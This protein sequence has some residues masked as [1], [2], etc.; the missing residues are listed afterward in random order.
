MGSDFLAGY[1]ARPYLGEC[2]FE[3]QQQ[4]LMDKTIRKI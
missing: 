1:Y 4:R 2:N 3:E